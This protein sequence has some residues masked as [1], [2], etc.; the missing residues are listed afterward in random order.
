MVAQL[1]ILLGNFSRAIKAVDHAAQLPGRVPSEDTQGIGVGI[2]D[3]ED[4]RQFQLPRQ[5]QLIQ[6]PQMLLQPELL[7]PLVVIVQTDLTDRDDTGHP[8]QRVQLLPVR[9]VL[10]NRP[11]GMDTDGRKDPSGI[12]GA[13]LQHFLAGLNTHA[14]LDGIRDIGVQQFP[15]Q[16]LPVAFCESISTL[17]SGQIPERLLVGVIVVMG[18][19]IDD[20]G[21]PSFSVL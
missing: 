21:Q 17:I 1:Q 14:R 6:K 20:H 2:P 10:I 11:G 18:M 13:K 9:P 7:L 16:L 12:C 19:G 3:V 5:I 15:E 4:H 8:C